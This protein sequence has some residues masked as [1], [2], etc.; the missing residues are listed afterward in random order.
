MNIGVCFMYCFGQCRC[1]VYVLYEE[2][3]ETDYDK[4]GSVGTWMDEED[5]RTAFKTKPEQAENI[6]KTAKTMEHPQRKVT[7]YEVLEFKSQ[8]GNNKE[9]K[10]RTQREG[11]QTATFKAAKK[12][13]AEPKEPKKNPPEKEKKHLALTEEQ[14]EK[15]TK[16]ETSLDK[17]YGQGMKATELAKEP[18]A[19]AYVTDAVLR[20][21]DAAMCQ[22]GEAKAT[23]SMML[24]ACW[25][26]DFQST[27]KEIAGAKSELTAKTKKLNKFL[28]LAEDN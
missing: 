20:E 12:V 19:K 9:N 21:H 23:V 13:K 15:V 16:F 17:I 26:G 4:F 22:V 14:K 2:N 1:F 28:A 3:A 5:V 7:M 6:L 24:D 8:A 10:K 18:K 27:W 11:T 25:L